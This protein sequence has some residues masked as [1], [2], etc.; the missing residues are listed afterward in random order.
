MS[1]YWFC[2][3]AQSLL[4]QAKQNTLSMLEIFHDF[5]S[6]ADFSKSFL[7][8]KIQSGLNWVL[9][10]CKGSQKKT[11]VIIILYIVFWKILLKIG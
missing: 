7:K 10:V 8:K 11:L 6:S 1:I 5:S 2:P 9:I 4:F 3:L